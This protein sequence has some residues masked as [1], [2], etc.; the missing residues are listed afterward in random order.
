VLDY[1]YAVRSDIADDRRQA[2]DM[3][4]AAIGSPAS[5]QKLAEAAFRDSNGVAGSGFPAAT[6]TNAGPVGAFAVDDPP[7]VQNAL[8][9]WA[10]V[11]EPPRALAL[12]DVSSSMKTKTSSGQTRADEMADA[13]HQGLNLLATDSEVGLW[14]FGS[15][16]HSDILSVAPLTSARR[17]NFDQRLAA[18]RPTGGDQVD[19][20]GTVLDAYDEMQSAYDPSRPN[21]LI[22]FTD[23]GDSSPTGQR[24][25]DFSKQ[26]EQVADPTEPIRIAIIGIDV[27]PDGAANLQQIANLVGGGYFPLTDEHQVPTILLKAL[28]AVGEA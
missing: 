15:A 24:L 13:T 27:P 23:G 19:L 11:N 2:A 22:L 9:L 8:N 6:E 28:L 1:P 7:R 25:M 4:R 17:A 3:F 26:I 16:G 14:T 20:Y 12:L 10:A 5:A 21:F 18:A